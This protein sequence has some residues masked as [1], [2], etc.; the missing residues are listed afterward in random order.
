MTDRI[1]R[2]RRTAPTAI[3]SLRL[4]LD[5]IAEIDRIAGLEE[6]SRSDLLRRSFALYKQARRSLVINLSEKSKVKLIQLSKSAN[7][8]P[9]TFAEQL[10]ET[11]I[12]KRFSAGRHMTMVFSTTISTRERSIV[13]SK[14][15]SLN[16]RPRESEDIGRA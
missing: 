12:D 9:L 10:L 15:P 13:V 16:F 14:P 2:S 8:A 6:G 5:T 1:Q 11:E 7:V 4:P 3:I